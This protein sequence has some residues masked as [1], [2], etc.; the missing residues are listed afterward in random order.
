MQL[1]DSNKI[2]M[3]RSSS[4]PGVVAVEF[5]GPDAQTPALK[6]VYTYGYEHE[7]MGQ[8]PHGRMVS[9]PTGMIMKKMGQLPH[10]RMVSIP[11]GMS[12]KKMGQ[13]PHGRMVSIPTGMIM[14]K[15]GQCPMEEWCLYLRV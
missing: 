14:K 4:S 1:S 10:G 6:F 2:T 7:K 13:L 15:M 11:T 3:S 5:S 9:I 8:L 12:T